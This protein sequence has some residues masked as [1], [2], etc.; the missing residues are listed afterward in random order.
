M[1]SPPI[2]VAGGG[3]VQIRDID[4]EPNAGG[5]GRIQLGVHPLRML[6]DLFKRRFDAS[7]GYTVHFAGADTIHHGFYGGAFL[8]PWTLEGDAYD[9]SICRLELGLIGKAMLGVDGWGGGGGIELRWTWSRFLLLE[10]VSGPDIAGVGWG[11]S[12]FGIGLSTEAYQVDGRLYALISF[13]INAD[14]PAFAG[15]IFLR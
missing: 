10:D 12:G 8:F 14:L 5:G 11:D 3:G 15:I 4:T 2:R 7:L 1:V 6:P 13:E 9:M